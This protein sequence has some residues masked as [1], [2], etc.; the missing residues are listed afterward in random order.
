MLMPRQAA[1]VLRPGVVAALRLPLPL[2]HFG[3]LLKALA[4]AYPDCTF[5]DSAPGELV[6]TADIPDEREAA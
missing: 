5:T 4:T 3:A 1:P 6:V 2:E